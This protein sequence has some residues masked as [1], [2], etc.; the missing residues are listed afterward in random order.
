M[1]QIYKYFFVFATLLCSALLLLLAVQYIPQKYLKNSIKTSLKALQTE[2]IYPSFGFHHRIIWL[3]NFDDALMLNTAY[4]SYE[5]QSVINSLLNYRIVVNENEPD[6]IMNLSVAYTNQ[7]KNLSGYQRYWHGYLVFIKPL[8]IFFSYQ[9]IRFLLLFL[10]FIELILVQKKV[11]FEHGL[12]RSVSLLIGFLFVD[13]LFLFK[14]IQ[15]SQ[16]FI[17][18]LTMS[19]IFFQGKE[20]KNSHALLFFVT[21]ILTSFFDLLTAPLVSFGILILSTYNM[22][23][24]KTFFK[25]LLS[26]SIGYLSFWISKW[27]IVDF[28]FSTGTILRSINQ[29]YLRTYGKVDNSF[30]V[31]NTLVL[32][33][34]QL[35]G[36][37]KYELMIMI[38]LILI[39]GI[40]S[41][42]FM[43]KR[44]TTKEINSIVCFGLLACLPYLWYMFAAN[45]SYIHFWFTYRQQL[46]SV[47][48]FIMI[49]NLSTNL[50][51]ISFLRKILKL[52]AWLKYFKIKTTHFWKNS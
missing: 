16:V 15:F 43:K 4:T 41:L 32:N 26:W 42:F 7:S 23:S 9:K 5:Y 47:S 37:S 33:F 3:D 8:L 38:F 6:Q 36:T 46:L 18:G 29:V 2:G 17:I 50:K 27:L 19:L 39:L 45:H 49:F 10:L 31:F 14:S 44:L 12:G 13:F 48:S 22:Q 20:L 24:P 30:N 11:Y 34:N 21:G 1:K 51:K 28:V 52:K 25:F 40:I 35:I